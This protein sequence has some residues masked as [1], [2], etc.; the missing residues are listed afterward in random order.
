M[1]SCSTILRI[2]GSKPMSNIRSAS[3]RQRYLE[4]KIL[5]SNNVRTIDRRSQCLLAALKTNLAAFEEI[6]QPTRR[7]HLGNECEIFLAKRSEDRNPGA[8]LT[9]NID[10][11]TDQEMAASVELPHLVAHVG[12]TVHDSRANLTRIKQISTKSPQCFKLC[13]KSR[14]SPWSGS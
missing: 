11:F 3:S 4:E 5:K 7:C 14:Y 12:A 1:L 9:I 13:S 10:H 2:C 6:N 8:F